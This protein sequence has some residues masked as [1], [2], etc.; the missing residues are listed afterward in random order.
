MSYPIS[1]YDLLSV[2]LSYRTILK[3]PKFVSCWLDLVYF[4]FLH[5]AEVFIKR[6]DGMHVDLSSWF[7]S[8][9]SRLILCWEVLHE[10]FNCLFP[11]PV[12]FVQVPFCTAVESGLRQII[13]EYYIA[14]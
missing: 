13:G 9:S 4:I 2:Q 14:Y 1:S 6:S 5:F 3:I 7:S 12:Y 10:D 11:Y 8:F